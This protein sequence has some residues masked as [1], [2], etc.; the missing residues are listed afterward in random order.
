MLCADARGAVGRDGVIPARLGTQCIE[1]MHIFTETLA[2]SG[3]R[4]HRMVKVDVLVPVVRAQAD[5]VALISDKIDKCKLPVQTADRRV[6]LPDGLPRLDGKAERRRVCEL[7]TD[8]GMRDPW[9]TPVVD[10]EIDARNLREPYGARLP[11]RRVVRVGAIVAV[12]DVV[13]GEFITV[14][15]RPCHLR[16]VGL[17]VAVI[18]WLLREPPGEYSDEGEEDSTEFL[19]R[20]AKKLGAVFLA[21]IAVLAWW[22]TQ[23]PSNDGNWQPDVAQ[24]AWAD[25]NGDEFTFHNVRNCDYRTDTD[26]TPRWETRTVRLSQITGIDLAI[27]YWGSPWIA[28]PIV[29]FQFADAP[30]LC[31]SIET[32]KT[33]GQSYSTIGGLYRQYTLIYLV[34]DERDVIRL[35]TNYRHED[36]YLYHTTAP[37]DRARER[38]VEYVYSLNALRT[39]PRWYN[40]VTTNCTTSIRTQHPSKERVPWDWRI[41]LNGKAD[42]MMYAHG[43]FVTGGLPFAELK[44][45]SLIDSRARAANDSPDFSQLIREGMP[46]TLPSDASAR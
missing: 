20:T 30:P 5:H 14:D 40:A 11:A 36:I 8:D 12:A 42:E 15:I 9:R 17:P 41:L 34:A 13:E 22:L 25:I 3:R 1:G 31:F 43:A 16:H 45:R 7:E 18:A 46:W 44:T 32:R 24:V 27:D 37:L 38:F 23:K 4:N 10:G 39:Q 35:R 21:F 33:T 29:S 2:R 19:R 26:Y 28:H 6:G